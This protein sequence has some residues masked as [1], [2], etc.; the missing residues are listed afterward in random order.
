MTDAL[1]QDVMALLGDDDVH[2]AVDLVL[3]RLGP[4]V[5]GYLVARMGHADEVSDVFALWS[6]DI[7][8]GLASF[9]GESSLRTWAYVLARHALARFHRD[10]KTKP[11]FGL[12]VD[13]E[14][15]L[16]QVVQEVKT[17][18]AA[19]L[20]RP[21]SIFPALSTTSNERALFAAS[22]TQTT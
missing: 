13:A 15:S 16:R 17:S 4:E 12:D 14:Q 3:R 19:F 11:F 20:T 2:G 7:W 22:P 1:T 10:K 8:K 5:G 21:A 18:T 9:K 6:V